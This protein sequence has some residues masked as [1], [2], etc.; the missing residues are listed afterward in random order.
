MNANCA[1]VKEICPICGQG[2]LLVAV[3][4][5]MRKDFFV[6][7][8]DC[9]SEWDSPDTASD[10]EMATRDKYKFL[11]YATVEDVVGSLWEKFILNK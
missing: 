7:C 9:E 4:D 11:K 1:V 10:M 2:R 3:D 5:S 8:E 6:L